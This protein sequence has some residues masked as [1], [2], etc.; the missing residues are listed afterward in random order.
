AEARF[1]AGEFR[2]H[3]LVAG[4]KG[5]AAGGLAALI[6]FIGFSWWSS[7]SLATPGAAQAAALFGNFTIG[8]TGYIGV[9][10]VVLVVAALTA[11]TSHATVITR[12]RDVEMRHP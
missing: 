3:F 8:K 10:L 9:V 6:V 2:R 11:V 12:L 4:M 7:S 5:A 1:I